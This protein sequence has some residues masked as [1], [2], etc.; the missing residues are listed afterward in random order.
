M[1]EKIRVA[2]AGGG[3]GGHF[4]PALNLGQAME[5]R[6]QAQLLFF[7][8]ARGIES[9]ILPQKGY[10]LT[11]L[12]VRGFQRRMTLKN[13]LF[14]INL[15]RSM[16]L[17]K[18][19]LRAFRP[20]LALGT[21][22]YVMGPVLRTAKKMGVPI[23]IQE[24]N[25]YPGVTTRLLAREANLLF[26]AY[27][28]ALEHLPDGVHA[29][30]TG[31]P[32]KMQKRFTSKEEA[33]KAL[34]FLADLP[35]VAVI[36]GSQGAESMNRAVMAALKSGLLPQKVQWLWQTGR[37]HFE[38]WKAEVKREKLRQVAVRPFIDEMA[39]VYQAADL[40]VCRA[41]AMTLSELMAMGC[42]AVL[43]PFPFA[44]GDHQFKNAQAVAQKGAAVVLKDDE[45]LPQKLMDLL[46]ALI[47]DQNKLKEMAKAMERL[48]KQDSI[49]Q[50][51]S[52]IEQLLK[53]RGVN[54]GEGL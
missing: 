11:L 41:G 25:S 31:N 15:L 16:A 4:F 43:V 37:Q 49:D 2:I 29:V 19:A 5:E 53:E 26:L 21:G 28:E 52:L 20:H 36:G 17:S 44:A 42:P 10:A 22:G 47:E 30:V 51:L 38:R 27:E 8:T 14:P 50:I 54:F 7:G 3:T 24:Q 33:K 39:T 40:M 18:K 6:W 13:L 34:G 1:K 46:P 32:I 48:H 45:K 35:L 12:P 9:S 23:V